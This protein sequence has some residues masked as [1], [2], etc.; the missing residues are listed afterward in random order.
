[1]S[2]KHESSLILAEAKVQSGF[3]LTIGFAVGSHGFL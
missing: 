3:N 1:M 2:K